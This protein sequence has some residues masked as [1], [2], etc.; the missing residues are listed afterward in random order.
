MARKS[1]DRAALA[2]ALKNA[3]NIHYYT[4]ENDFAFRYYDSSLTIY[5]TLGDTMGMAKASNNLGVVF[6]RMG[7]YRRSLEYHLHSL[8]MKKAM[9]DSLSEISSFNNIGS[10]YYSI[11]SL[12]EALANFR[13][14]L[15]YA[16]HLKN[17][18]F[19]HILLS[20][21]GMIHM[22]KG[23][24][25]TARE[26]FIRSIAA[27][28]DSDNPEGLANVYNNLGRI[29]YLRKDFDRAV[30][31]YE[32]ALRQNRQIGLESALILNNIAQVYIEKG[33]YSA[34]G[35][36][37]SR[38]L[39]DAQKTGDINDLKNI[40][41]NFSVLFER[42]GDYASAF[43]QYLM[44]DKFQDSLENQRYNNRL[45]EIQNAYQTG[46][47][48][49]E[50]DRLTS[51]QQLKDLEIAHNRDALHRKNMIIA[52][53][54]GFSIALLIISFLLFRMNRQIRKAEETLQKDQETLR[55]IFTSSPHGIS[56]ADAN[57]VIID[58]NPAGLKLFR[59]DSRDQIIG[60]NI[61]DFIPREDRT[62]AAE[63]FRKAMIQGKNVRNDYR[64]LR[65]DDTSFIAELSSASI[66]DSRGNSVAVVTNIIDVTERSR[67]IEELKMARD[68]AEESDRLKSA[69]LANMS[70]EI[71]TPMNSLVGFAHLLLDQGLS[72][73]K[74]REY[75]QYIING[76]N[77]LMHI[78][79]DIVDI[80]K[81]EA[82]QLN[83]SFAECDM[84]ELMTGLFE[85][86]DR[87]RTTRAVKLDLRLPG[88]P[89]SSICYTDPHRVRQIMYNLIGNGLKFTEEGS[90]EFGYETDNTEGEN[91]FVFFVRDTGP[92]IPEDKIDK[93]FERFMQ[94]DDSHTRR[95]GGTGLGLAISRQLA[96]LLGGKLWVV[97]RLGEGS[98]FYFSIPT[99]IKPS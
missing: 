57:G 94:G 12:D 40:R 97:S 71:R 59:L 42:Q 3:G 81:I 24:L 27:I 65:S 38:A 41:K 32:E 89:H 1:G 5:R 16:E 91:H 64:L 75:L 56:L 72:A 96:G 44:Y 58:C 30:Y 77:T 39:A 2:N 20:N 63:N 34:A 86:M 18:A 13:T 26:H 15:D 23:D 31:Y 33:E 49:S 9:H 78:I 80:S 79:N 74:S 51:D 83:L 6:N 11:G 85:E 99:K 47:M 8:K 92:G 43:E 62:L 82:G 60:K 66:R 73:R 52:G 61:T 90:V 4:G 50:I 35:D 28:R 45:I 67:F 10:I 17:K 25:E 69:F 55:Q 84:R 48:E 54:V 76:S 88:M 36:F 46:R 7:L 70:H 98:T 93:V 37:L 19:I 95:Y 29:H 21:I 68:K 22:D 53:I 14:A 87:T